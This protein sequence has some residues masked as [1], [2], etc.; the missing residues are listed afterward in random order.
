M[1]GPVKA[2]TLTRRAFLKSGAGP[3]AL[4]AAGAAGVLGLHR[5]ATGGDTV[6]QIDPD[7]CIQCDRCTTD[8]VL[9]PSAVKCVHAYDV[10]GYCNRCGG[11]HQ[12]N[13]KVTDTAAE[14]QLCPTSAILRTFVEDP[15]YHYDIDEARCIGCGKC[16]K[17]CGS[18]GNGSLFLQI[19]H[20]RCVNCNQCAIAQACPVQAISRAPA[21]QPYRL[22]GKQGG[23][24]NAQA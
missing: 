10:C 20:D 22:R 2:I 23:K 13:A 24:P 18:F 6:W 15:Y 9:A 7:V 16:V 5:A 3:V 17:G 11:F 1:T 8:C 4:A 19:R 12:P 14:N 21:A